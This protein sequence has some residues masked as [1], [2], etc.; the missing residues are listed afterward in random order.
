[1]TS[2]AKIGGTGGAAA[3]QPPRV[4]TSRVITGRR[5]DVVNVDQ[6]VGSRAA[7]NWLQDIRDKSLTAAAEK[8]RNVD[9]L[10][11]YQP[12]AACTKVC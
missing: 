1:M 6:P 4:G 9:K 10:L 2:N 7:G 11:E 3:A 12:L 5:K 8:Y